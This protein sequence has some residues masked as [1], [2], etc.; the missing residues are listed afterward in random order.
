[1]SDNVLVARLIAQSINASSIL[2]AR[3]GERVGII[4]SGCVY[5]L[6]VLCDNISNVCQYV[7]VVINGTSEDY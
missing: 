5:P 7:D 6:L 3:L 1:M 2:S 4:K